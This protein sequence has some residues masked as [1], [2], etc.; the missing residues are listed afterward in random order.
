MESGILSP[1]WGCA[2]GA[3]CDGEFASPWLSVRC[4]VG[5]QIGV[6]GRILG[7]GQADA[8]EDRNGG[9]ACVNKF[10]HDCLLTNKGFRPIALLGRHVVPTAGSADLIKARSLASVDLRQ[11]H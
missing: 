9:C 8:A 6:V 1:T 2:A 7:G 11:Y 5:G 4:W 3:D 10:A